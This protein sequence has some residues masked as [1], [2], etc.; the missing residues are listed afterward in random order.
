[1]TSLQLRTMN[2][3]AFLSLAFIRPCRCC[4]AI[5]VTMGGV[6][7]NSVIHERYESSI[8]GEAP[9][10]E[11]KKA[12]FGVGPDG[13]L[14]IVDIILGTDVLPVMFKPGKVLAKGIQF[15]EQ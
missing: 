13:V 3:I 2:N 8:A 1:M 9:V 12:V 7:C 5:V 10:E 11:M 6:L 4:A 14:A 15:W